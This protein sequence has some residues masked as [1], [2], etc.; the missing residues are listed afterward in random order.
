[1]NN[2]YPARSLVLRESVIAM[3]YVHLGMLG[4]GWVTLS[5][6]LRGRKGCANTN[7]WQV[8]HS[9][10]IFFDIYQQIFTSVII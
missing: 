9:L 4:W 5:G 2:Y 1:M 7:K 6:T 10:S 8:F 3:T